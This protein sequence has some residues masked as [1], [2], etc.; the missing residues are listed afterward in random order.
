[1]NKPTGTELGDT[2]KDL[3]AVEFD[4]MEK[5]CPEVMRLLIQVIF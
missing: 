1:M 2:G 3:T 4:D 5:L